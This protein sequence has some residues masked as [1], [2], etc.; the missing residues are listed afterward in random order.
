MRG[1]RIDLSGLHR[2]RPDIAAAFSRASLQA[3]DLLLAI[4]GTY[5]R[6]AIVPSELEGGNITQD[7][8]RLAISPLADARFV[9]THLQ[10]KRSQNYFK[11][12]ARG[13]AVKGVNIGDVRLCPVALPPLAEQREIVI[14]IERRL[15]IVQSIEEEVEHGLKRAARLRKSILNRAFSG[16]LVPQEDADGAVGISPHDGHRAGQVATASETPK[17]TK[18]SGRGSVGPLL[19]KR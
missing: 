17:N 7:T 13:V 9:M 19:R 8:A 14:E 15:S 4:R 3:G 2:T 18:R 1:D 12:V 10:A 11:H 16:Q 6:L 5:G